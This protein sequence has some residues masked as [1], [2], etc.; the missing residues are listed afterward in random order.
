MKVDG[1]TIHTSESLV[2]SLVEALVDIV[3]LPHY[4]SV[5]GTT[6]TIGQARP[7][8]TWKYYQQAVDAVTTSI[9]CE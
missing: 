4:V 3:E 6:I 5:E 7:Q 8:E 2:G 1:N 9:V